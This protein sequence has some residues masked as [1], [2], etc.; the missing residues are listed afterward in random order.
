M[1]KLRKK[2]ERSED[3]KKKLRER[4]GNERQRALVRVA[5]V[6]LM[7]A[8]LVV[9]VMMVAAQ[10]YPDIALL[11]A[12]RR[13]VARVIT[14]VQTAFSSATDG[15]AGYLRRLKLRSNLEYE[16][17]QLLTRLEEMTDRTML[18]EA[19]QYQLQ[20]YADLDDEVSGNPQLD[21]IK[22][23]IIG[24][25]TSNYTFTLTINVGSDHGI[26]RA[27]AV[28]YNGALVGYIDSVEK[29]SS[30]VRAIVDSN[31][32]V[33]ALIESSRDQGHLSGTLAIDGTYAC[34]MY[35]LTYT[36]LP[37]PGD[38]VVTSGVGLEFIKGIPIGHVRESTRGQEDSK[39]FIVVEPIVDFEHL[40]YVVVFRYVPAY[41]EPAEERGSQ[42]SSTFVPLPAIQPVPTYIGQPEPVV[43]PGPDGVIPDPDA[44]T[45]EPSPEVTET[46]RPTEDPNA[47]PRPENFAYNVRPVTLGTPTPEPTATPTP[48][49]EPAPT[50]SVDQQTVEEDP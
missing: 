37:R 33:N 18:Y 44:L 22:A 38:R 2:G 40:E 6:G 8:L 15:V 41:P 7:V 47:T 4:A 24:R 34:R 5:G 28:V 39:Q 49:P 21:G 14:P 46:P 29:S 36:T 19:M 20:Q 31:A 43:T 23:N 9:I 1:R 42:V 32:S 12:P 35:Y 17:E 11:D 27:M 26:D 45:P 30:T 13:F 3:K 25:D 50:F 16:Y 48:S 10:F